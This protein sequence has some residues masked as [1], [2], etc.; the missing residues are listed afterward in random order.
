MQGMNNF[1]HIIIYLY[2]FLYSKF[3]KLN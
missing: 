1:D 2:I 3:Y